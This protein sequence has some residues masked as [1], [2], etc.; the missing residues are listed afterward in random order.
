[1]I[2]LVPVID[3]GQIQLGDILIIDDGINLMPATVK[4]ILNAGTENEEI[5]FRKK[6]NEYFLVDMYL[7]G[8]SWAKE[9]F[10]V[11]RSTSRMHYVGDKSETT[12]DEIKWWIT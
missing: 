12:I 7:K 1:M 3:F 10:I 9:I 8:E 2:N 11:K 6:K 4:L 5:I